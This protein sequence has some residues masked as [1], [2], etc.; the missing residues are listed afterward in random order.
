MPE[1]YV[2]LMSGTSLD[3]VDAVVAELAG[4]RPRILGSVHVPFERDLR[5]QLFALTESGFGEIDAAGRLGNAL[6]ELYARAV[7]EALSVSH[8]PATSILAIGCHGQTVRHRPEQRFTLQIGN[9][10]LL[11]ELTGIAVA[12]DFRSRDIAAGGQGAP[13]VPAFHAAVFSDS[14]ENR[15]VLNLGGIANITLLPCGSDVH[16]YDIGPGNCLMDAWM[17]RHLNEPLDRGGAWAGGSEPLR[18]L[19]DRLLREPY[20]SRPA[21]K[22]CGRELFNLSWLERFLDGSEAPQAVQATLL[23]LT[24]ETVARTIE[25]QELPPARLIVCGGGARNETLVRRISERLATLIV[26]SSAE[27]G[28]DV[29]QVEATAFAWLAQRTL[30]NRAGNLPAVTGASGLRVLGAIYPA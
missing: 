7:R 17:Q 14:A 2:G 19:L 30:Q 15:A 18:H 6:A 10:A 16:G 4:A 3:G 8:T 12:A 23:E 5:E 20:F 28:L 9:P 13:L 25:V 29:E 27:F 1:V 21:P 24:V 22:S 26:S 11:A